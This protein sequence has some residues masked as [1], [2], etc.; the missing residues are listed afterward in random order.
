[1]SVV[2]IYVR[3]LPRAEYDD[4]RCP[5]IADFLASLWIPDLFVFLGQL[6]ALFQLK[7]PAEVPSPIKN[8]GTFFLL[9]Q[10]TNLSYPPLSLSENI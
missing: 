10:I 1:M 6:S 3:T 8:N 7:Q 5:L 4:W 2:Q 9:T